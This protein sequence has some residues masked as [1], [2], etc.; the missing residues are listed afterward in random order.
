MKSLM[1]GRTFPLAVRAVAFMLCAAIADACS[2]SSP[3]PLPSPLPLRVTVD[4]IAHEVPPDTTFGGLIDDLH[5]HASNGRL[6]SV[7]GAILS[8][9]ADPGAILLNGLDEVR[10]TPLVNGDVVRVVNGKDR[11][12]GVRR[13]V[14]DIGRRVGNPERTLDTYPTERIMVVGR[15]SHDIVSVTDVSKGRGRAPKAVAL[16]FDDGPWPGDTER[17]L[18]VLKRYRVPATFFMVG[19]LIRR[20]PEIVHAVRHAGQQIENHSFDHPISP[21]LAE[22]TEQ[23]ITGEINDVN[24]ALQR[25]GVHPTLFR[26]PGGSYNDFVIQEARTLGMRIVMWSVDP[27][28]WKSSRTA[29]QVRRSVLARV[30]PGSIIL[31][32]DG[33]G[34]AAHT[35]KALPGIIRGI[36]KR[37]LHFVLVPARPS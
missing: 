1:A 32:H 14:V 29:K 21:T 6:L 16:T 30:E 22:L 5:L 3:P 27:K 8:P 9:I 28:D 23:R 15:V 26:P 36:R 12:E 33:G 25:D 4:R 18:A 37:G 13:T 34:D 24:A 2:G 7:S 31:L 10:Y 17:V 19:Y 35:I 11:T 20:Y